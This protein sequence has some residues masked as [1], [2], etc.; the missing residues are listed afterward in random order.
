MKLGKFL[1]VLKPDANAKHI[2]NVKSPK[3]IAI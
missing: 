1:C 3:I 2:K